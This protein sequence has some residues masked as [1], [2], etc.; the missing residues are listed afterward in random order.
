MRRLLLVLLLFLGLAVSTA[1]LPAEEVRADGPGVSPLTGDTVVAL[2]RYSGH[3]EDDM[4]A[5]ATV[6]KLVTGSQDGGSIAFIVYGLVPSEPLRVAAGAEGVDAAGADALTRVREGATS[7]LS[8]QFQA[9]AGSLSYLSGIEAPAGSRLFLVTNGK[10]DAASEAAEESLIS[11]GGLFAESGW[12]VNPV[13]VPSAS[14]EDRELMGRL[15]NS[16]GGAAYDAGTAQG[17]ERLLRDVAGVAASGAMETSVSPDAPALLAFDVPPRTERLTV[18]FVRQAAG[19]EISVFNPRGGAVTDDLV[20]VQAFETPNTLVFGVEDP[21]AGVWS[22]QVDGP[23]SMVLGGVELANPLEVVMVPQAPL[24]A[25]EMGVLEAAVM[26]DGRREALSG[27]FIEATVSQPDGSTR[28]YRL[29]DGGRGGDEEAGDG[30]FAT[31]VPASDAQGVNDVLLELRWLQYGGAIQGAGT[32][33]T[34]VFPVVTVAPGEPAAISS[35]GTAVVA[36]VETTAGGYPYMVFPAEVEAVVTAGEGEVFPAEVVPRGVLDGGRAW[37]FDVRAAAPSSGGY[38]VDVSLGGEYLGRAFTARAPS[39]MTEVEVIPPPVTMLSRAPAPLAPV[40]VLEARAGVLGLPVWAWVLM[41]AGL[42]VSAA[43]VG[44]RWALKA[45]P[46]GY[47]YDDSDRLVVDFAR[48]SRGLVRRVL[49]RDR[50]LSAEVPGLPLGGGSF[51]FSKGRVELYYRPTEGAPSLRANSRP[52]GAVTELNE[53]TWLGIGGRLLRF[54]G[55]PRVAR[56][57]AGMAGD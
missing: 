41:G 46:Y 55:S 30:V 57:A 52:A 28:V 21:V 12:S 5:G 39:V 8:N 17:I 56:T 51:R 49:A 13:M 24:P 32:F 10:Q 35:G 14:P 2:D 7:R 19:V 11:L 37:Q 27:A 50:V 16:T 15:A 36:R 44:V 9:L 31:A 45:K 33:R 25:G 34:E 6:V 48:L 18:S 23:A 29:E 42:V 53:D 54:A 4:A 1:Y 20:T 43:A 47:I 26:V 22:V 38:S 40:P 3:R